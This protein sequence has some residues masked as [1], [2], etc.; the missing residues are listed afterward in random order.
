MDKNKTTVVEKNIHKPQESNMDRGKK[1]PL[2]ENSGLDGHKE[3]FWE[4]NVDSIGSDSHQRF[5]GSIPQ[6]RVR[7]GLQK[8]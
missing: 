2:Q 6:Q 4:F 3:Q 5:S 1:W 7:E 8:L